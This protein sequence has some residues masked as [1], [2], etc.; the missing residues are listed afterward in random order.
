MPTGSVTQANMRLSIIAGT[1]FCDFSSASVLTD[2]LGYRLEISDSAG[3]KLVGYIKAAGTG[4]TYTELS[5]NNTA[6]SD[7]QTEANATTGWSNFNSAT[8][9]ESIASGT[10][11]SGSY[12]F[13]VDNNSGANRGF[14]CTSL[15]FT[16]EK[17]YKFISAK[18]KVDGTNPIVSLWDGNGSTQLYSGGVSSTSY[19]S[20]TVYRTSGVTGSSGTIRMASNA[21]DSEFYADSFSLGTVNTPSD[22][23]V[24]ITSI[25]DGS[26]YN[27]ASE[28]S[29]FN[30]ND[31]SGYTYLI[32]KSLPVFTN[33]YSFRRS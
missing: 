27:W 15:S 31:S 13:H 16:S 6:I 1:A 26:T 21:G 9:F 11:Y 2:Y 14:Q 25:A 30:R 18:K 4:E 17:L 22:T 33:Q 32:Q 3:K 12:H 23:G 5:P 24:T 28:E 19:S 29:G 8:V 7:S 20:V 10:P